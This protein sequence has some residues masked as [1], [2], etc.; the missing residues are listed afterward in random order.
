MRGVVF[1]NSARAIARLWRTSGPRRNGIL[2]GQLGLFIIFMTGLSTA[3]F[4]AEPQ[5]VVLVGAG[6]SVPLPLYRKWAELYNQSNKNVQLQYVAM[7]SVEGVA[8]ISHGV[9]DFGAGEGPL[10]A[11]ERRT[12]NLTELPVVII[13]IVP[14]YNLPGNPQMR[15]SGEVLADIYL[16]HIKYWNDP[17]IKKLNPGVNLPNMSINLVYRPGGKGSN[18]IFTEFLS[19]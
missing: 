12:G 13:G 11:E 5:G 16:G 15:F 10:T 18:Y 19:R 6:S 17:A 2:L 3:L 14:I 7:G 1:R 8:Q 4:A 9:S